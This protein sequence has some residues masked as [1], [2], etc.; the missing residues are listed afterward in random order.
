VVQLPLAVSHDFLDGKN[1]FSCCQ[2]KNSGKKALLSGC[3]PPSW[4][5]G[6]KLPSG[7]GVRYLYHPGKLEGVYRRAT[8]PLCSLQ[9]YRLRRAV[10]KH[11]EPVLYY[12]LDGS[13]SGFVRAEVHVELL[14]LSC[15][16]KTVSN[17][18]VASLRSSSVV[19]IT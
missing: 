14:T 15:R 6:E 1:A 2:G 7:V 13:T 9:V 10:P 4:P 5:R 11:G 16:R 18:L 3:W 8:E 19:A 17:S 12:L